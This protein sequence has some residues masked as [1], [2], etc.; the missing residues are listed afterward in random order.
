MVGNGRFYS[1]NA[2]SY[3]KSEYKM[4]KKTNNNTG[5]NI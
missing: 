4:K 5:K 2:N 3:F 1:N